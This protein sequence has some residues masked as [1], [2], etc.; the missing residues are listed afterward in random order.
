MVGAIKSN[1]LANCK[2][3]LMNEGSRESNDYKEHFDIIANSNF[4]LIC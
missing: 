4:G 1:A 2:L 3:E